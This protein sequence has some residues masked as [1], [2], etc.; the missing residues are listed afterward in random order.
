ML[1]LYLFRHPE[2]PRAF[3][4]SWQQSY[5]CFERVRSAKNY[6]SLKKVITK[7]M[8]KRAMVS[9]A[10]TDCIELLIKVWNLISFFKEDYRSRR[11]NA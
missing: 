11:L 10:Q 6:T 2:S 4:F 5:T 7:K 3:R 8:H 9:I 1:S